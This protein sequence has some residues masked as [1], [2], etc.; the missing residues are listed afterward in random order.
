MI[1]H[2]NFYEAYPADPNDEIYQKFLEDEH[3]LSGRCYETDK[4]IIIGDVGW[5]DYSFGNQ[6]KYTDEDLSNA[7]YLL[8]F[9]S[10]REV[11][12]ITGISKSTLVR[13]RKY[14]NNT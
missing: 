9:H 10:Y 14:I 7:V 11:I 2:N 4:H 1:K 13:A 6:E 12:S 3:C 5:Y 8:S